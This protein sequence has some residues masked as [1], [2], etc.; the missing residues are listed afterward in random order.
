MGAFAGLDIGGTT[1][2]VA[3]EVDGQRSLRTSPTGIDQQDALAARVVEAIKEAVDAAGQ[4]PTELAGIG[5]AL[6]GSVERRTGTVRLATN[7][8]I[9]T[10]PFP[11]S[12]I[13]SESLDAPVSVENDV[14]TA[15]LGLAGALPDPT[16]ATVTYVSVGTGIASATVIDGAVLRG[17]H[18]SAGEIGQIQLDPRGRSLNGALPGSLEALASGPAIDR[19][20]GPREAA[21]ASAIRYLALGL[22]MLWMT[23]DPDIMVLGGGVTHNVGFE[24]SLRREIEELRS[25]SAVTAS[26]IDLSRLRVLP[27]DAVPGIDGALHLARQVQQESGGATHPAYTGGNTT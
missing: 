20:V 27:I 6:P 15:A 2:R 4:S 3:V 25:Q 11:L 18:G 1:T 8:G 22:H 12:S 10:A 16:R 19:A 26:I 24:R 14:K 17:V 13:I 9:G 7:L 23:F 5:I 21:L